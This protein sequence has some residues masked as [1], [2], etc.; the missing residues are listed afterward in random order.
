MAGYIFDVW[1]Q[2]EKLIPALMADLL[3]RLRQ[4]LQYHQTVVDV[5]QT[6]VFAD[7]D[8]KTEYNRQYRQQIR[9]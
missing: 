6:T 8:T 1:I 4:F 2:N 5:Y 7:G 3:S 9:Y